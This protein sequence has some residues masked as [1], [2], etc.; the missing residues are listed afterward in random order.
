MG[1]DLLYRKNDVLHF[2]KA[3]DAKPRKCYDFTLDKIQ[4]EDPVDIKAKDDTL[5]PEHER[6]KEGLKSNRPVRSSQLYGWYAPID[7]PKYGFERTRICQDSFMDKSHL[8]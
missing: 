4:S 5:Y 2:Y 6:F 8:S 1:G 3:T 7:L